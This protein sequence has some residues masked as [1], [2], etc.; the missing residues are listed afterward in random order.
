VWW[1]VSG[2]SNDFAQREFGG[3]PEKNLR[4]MEAFTAET[5]RAQR[6]AKSKTPA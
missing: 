6:K 3:K 4:R 2:S 1:C 5:Q